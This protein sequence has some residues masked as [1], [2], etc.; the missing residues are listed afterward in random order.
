[1]TSEMGKS[2]WANIGYFLYQLDPEV[3]RLERLHMKILKKK[4]ST[5]FNQA[6]LDND[7]LPRYIYIIYIY[8]CV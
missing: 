5:I 7:L 1:M 3:R 2:S 6:C 4:L 8:C